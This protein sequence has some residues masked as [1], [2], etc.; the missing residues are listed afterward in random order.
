LLEELA[1]RKQRTP[2]AALWTG[3]NER[4]TA[5]HPRVHMRSH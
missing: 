5:A 4:R 1:A 2:I 3:Q